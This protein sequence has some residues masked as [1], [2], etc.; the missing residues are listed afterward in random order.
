MYEIHH[1]KPI[2]DGGRIYDMRNMM[3]STPRVHDYILPGNA[4]YGTGGRK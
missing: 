4:H 1:A 3:I 2:K